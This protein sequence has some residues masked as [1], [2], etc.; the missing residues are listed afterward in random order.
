ML[1]AYRRKIESYE[2]TVEKTIL[3][4][5]GCGSVC[6][7]ELAQGRIIRNQKYTRF[8]KIVKFFFFKNLMEIDWK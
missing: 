7:V 8:G 1:F 2:T 6:C 3:Q 5:E 4:T